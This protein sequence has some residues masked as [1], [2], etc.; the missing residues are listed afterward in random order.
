MLGGIDIGGTKI[1]VCVGSADGAIHAHDRFPTDPRADPEPVLRRALETLASLASGPV[2]SVGVSCPGPFDRHERRFLTPPNLPAWHGFDLGAF[3]DTHAGAPARAMNDANSTALAEWLWGG[4][5]ARSTLVYLTM[6]TGFGAGIVVDGEVL[7][8]ASG[9]AGEVGRV[10][11][12]ELGPVGFGAMGTAEGFL[13]GPGM[14]QLAE[15]ERLACRQR[16]E[17]TALAGADPLDA[18]ALC[19]AAAGG[20]AAARR[21]TDLVAGRL[22]ELIAIVANLLEPDVV[23]LGTI[24]SAHPGLFVPG[25]GESM[26][27]RTVPETAAKLRIVPS[28]LEQRGSLSALAAAC[29]ATR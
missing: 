11:L 27:R 29:A 5:D 21:V 7:E 19:R 10:Q 13:S 24:G 16:G 8:G 18:E 6:S 22:G 20:D 14:A 28:T 23:V 12:A 26:R 9:F 1:G 17:A 15:A 2:G 4:H 3:L 25:A